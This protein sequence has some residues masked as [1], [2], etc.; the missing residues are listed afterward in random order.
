MRSLRESRGG[1]RPARR[2]PRFPSTPGL[3]LPAGP[4]TWNDPAGPGGRVGLGLG[5]DSRRQVREGAR[6][7]DSFQHSRRFRLSRRR[8]SRVGLRGFEPESDCMTA[9]TPG[10]SLTRSLRLPA[11]LLRPS[12]RVTAAAVAVNLN[13]G[14]IDSE[15]KFKA[16][17]SRQFFI[18]RPSCKGC[19][20]SRK[21][22]KA[23]RTNG[24]NCVGF[25]GVPALSKD[26]I[27]L[28]RDDTERRSS[29]RHVSGSMPARHGAR[30]WVPANTTWH[31]RMVAGT[32]A[33]SAWQKSTISFRIRSSFLLRTFK[34]SA[35]PCRHLQPCETPVPS[36]TPC[37]L[38]SRT[39]QVYPA[40]VRHNM[41]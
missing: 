41:P 27:C 39:L 4:R 13:P 28:G 12:A 30:G 25:T 1:G 37:V 7:P 24:V 14:R 19:G 10:R 29:Q 38:L 36:S 21:Q 8:E 6:L 34:C 20:G 11:Q 35:V 3:G 17:K 40:P 9:V 18:Q 32:W 23:M 26:G 2:G 5:V 33:R 22:P 16:V 15:R 31:G